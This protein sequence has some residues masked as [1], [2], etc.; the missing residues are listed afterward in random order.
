MAFA[1]LSSR[2]TPPSAIVFNLFITVQ[3]RVNALHVQ[4]YTCTYSYIHVLREQ[5]T[6]L[7]CIF[8]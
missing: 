1:Q 6:V 5:V 7:F 8:R 4:S 2:V 3:P